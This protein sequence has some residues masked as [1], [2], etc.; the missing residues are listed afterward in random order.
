[1]LGVSQIEECP[2]F[3]LETEDFSLKTLVAKKQA[4]VCMSTRFHHA[5]LGVVVQCELGPQS[6]HE[7]SG[8]DHNLDLIEI[9]SRKIFLN[10]HADNGT[11]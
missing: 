4:R 3:P 1:M 10:V 5:L 6:G 7:V 11:C 8:S 9:N 2:P